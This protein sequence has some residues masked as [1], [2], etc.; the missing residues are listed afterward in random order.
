MLAGHGIVFL[1]LWNCSFEHLKK[2]KKQ[3]IVEQKLYKSSLLIET[4]ICCSHMLEYFAFFHFSWQL[5][6]NVWKTFQKCLQ[7]RSEFKQ[8]KVVSKGFSLEKKKSCWQDKST[9]PTQRRC[10]YQAYFFSKKCSGKGWD[11]HKKYVTECKFPQI[12]YDMLAHMNG[13]TTF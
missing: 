4:K 8:Y 6:Q 12:I 2:K 13:E 9:A 1:K 3:D 5:L 7:A 11:K 10:F